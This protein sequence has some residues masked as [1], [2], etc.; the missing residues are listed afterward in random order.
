MVHRYWIFQW[1][2]WIFWTTGISRGSDVQCPTQGNCTC[3]PTF[4]RDYQIECRDQTNSAFVFYV[5]PNEH[6][7]IECQNSPKWADF[8]VL[9][10]LR[11]MKM[12]YLSF[13][14]CDLPTNI[15]LGE[16]SRSLGVLE[17]KKLTFQSY[18]NLTSKLTKEHLSG[19]P[20]LQRL[21]LSSNNLTKLPRNLF[22]NIP[23]LVW[24]DLRENN[25]Q[26][27]AGIFKS[28]PELEVLELG[29][30]NI[31][32]I[33]QGLF[34]SLG[35]L[36][37]LNLWRNKFRKLPAKIFD[38]LDSLNSLDLNSNN[39]ESLP[40]GIFHDLKKLETL[41]L[42]MNNFSQNGLPEGLLEK[43]SKLNTFKL[44]SNKRNLTSLPKG[45]LANLTQLHT[46]ELKRN[47]L[48]ELPED[49]FY[50]SVNLVNI[51]IQRNYLAH[52]PERLFSGL[53]QLK[54]LELNFNELTTLL[55][56][57][58]E[59]LESLESL[60]LSRNHLESISRNLLRSLRSLKTLDMSR[61]RLKIIE[62]TSFNYLDNL[63]VAIFSDNQL[64]FNTSPSFFHEFGKNSPFHACI[65]LEELHLARN[66]ITE[67]F[68]DWVVITLKLRIL[69]LSHNQ[70]PQIVAEDLQF[71]SNNIRVDLRD[72]L[73]RQISLATA[74]RISRFQMNPRDV[75]ILVDRNPLDCDCEV[76]NLI[77]YLEGDMPFA[78]NY[79]HIEIDNLTC[80]SPQWLKNVAV[81]DLKSKYFK[82]E[83]EEPCPSDCKC[84]SEPKY[85]E[86]VVDCSYKNLMNPPNE[87]K[88]L[89]GHRLVVDLTGN[90]LKD[91]NWQLGADTEMYKLLLGNNSLRELDSKE[92]PK[93]LSVLELH[94][95]NLTYLSPSTLRYLSHSNLSAITLD[96]NPWE[97]NCNSLDF[98]NFIQTKISTIS[99]SDRIR[100]RNRNKPV[101]KM[102]AADLCP[103]N[104]TTIMIICGTVALLG[105]IF[106]SVAA[107]YYRY[108]KEIKIWLYS[109][110]ICLFLVTE[111]ELDKDKTYDA[112][113]SYS[114]KD[115]EFVVNE[116]VPKLENGPRK[117]K[118]CLHFR[119]WLAGEWIPNQIARSVEDSRRTVVILSPNFLESVWG[120]MEFRAAHRQ[121][122]TEGRARVILVLYGDIG[123]TE[124]LDPELKAYIS[125]N[126]YVKWGDPWFWDKLRYALPHSQKNANRIFARNKP[127]IQIGEK[128]ELIYNAI[129]KSP[130]TTT[131]PADAINIKFICD[132]KKDLNGEKSPNSKT[133]F[134]LSSE[135]L[136][137][138][139]LKNKVQCSTV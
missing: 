77:R 14:I 25:V 31:A 122:L 65:N 42:F 17:T 3:I 129:N 34:S 81:R 46:V 23:K 57:T 9:N 126:T 109:H 51:S 43:T 138:Y 91:L 72:N 93:N 135:E 26:L 28:T 68:N 98:L 11:P 44:Y 105:I 112:F 125:M 76:Y 117:Y 39:L 12:N 84:Y 139:N 114:H 88:S 121:A 123:N 20:D 124:D 41:N 69:D 52:L 131:P 101:I 56:G 7:R 21:T 115:E 87:I 92:L 137:K 100:C 66:N 18:G 119:D 1:I 5:Q 55:D 48:V 74:E 37:F 73:I 95:N 32:E 35:K 111:N 36:R 110:Q 133:A 90:G 82:C 60:N 128:N 4:T 120:R 6:L 29:D 47:G 89:E 116:L 107:L 40:K 22:E 62:D 30:N 71:L 106:G 54:R 2:L 64:T 136:I 13:R 86:F 53:R 27:P 33:P 75:I 70:I 127:T 118:L 19:Y 97:C 83:V 59:D 103:T 10:V 132:D 130:T 96:D 78:S 80:E 79:F 45:F 94:S 24:L 85:S 104:T 63:R 16:I 8:P 134:I 113:I 15:S 108:Q 61:N 38:K 58:F 50:N 99:Q 49:L 67:I 102:I